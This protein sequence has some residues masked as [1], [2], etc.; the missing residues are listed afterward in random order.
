MQI[1]LHAGVHATD[2]DRLIKCMLRNKAELIQLGTGV[3]GP[4]RYRRQLRDAMQDVAKSPATPLMRENL[5]ALMVEQSDTK[6]LVLSH[7]NFFCVP[8]LAVNNGKFYDRAEQKLADFISLFS[9]PTDQIELMFAIRNPATYLPLVFEEAPDTDFSAFLG[10]T[11]PLDLRWSEML[12]RIHEALPLLPITVWCNEDTPL[13]WHELLQK[14]GGAPGNMRMKG[15]FNILREI[16]SREGIDKLTA[17]EQAHP[18][19]TEAQLRQAMV[20]FLDRYFLPEAIEQE[21]DLPGWDDDMITAMTE[22]Y[23][24][25]L[26]KIEEMSGITFLQS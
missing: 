24:D 6:R 1:V 7:D 3:P 10:Q 18:N 9:P 12:A 17:Y 11:R 5:L 20:V 25:D 15:G 23:E 22:V 19:M 2:E 16:M 13:L 4:S 21:I 26:L 14:V 8:K